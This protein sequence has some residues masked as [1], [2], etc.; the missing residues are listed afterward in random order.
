MGHGTTQPRQPTTS[1]LGPGNQARQ[2]LSLRHTPVTLP[3]AK[4]ITKFD[5]IDIIVTVPVAEML[6]KFDMI[7]IIVA[8]ALPSLGGRHHP[9]VGI[10]ELPRRV[11]GA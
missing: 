4:M 9:W 8:V 6:K 7:D 10:P 2:C 11:S 5:M 1:C 3:V